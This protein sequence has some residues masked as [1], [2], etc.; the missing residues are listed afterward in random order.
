M[1]ITEKQRRALIRYTHEQDELW[2]LYREWARKDPEGMYVVCGAMRDKAEELD[3]KGMEGIAFNA[4]VCFLT[5]ILMEIHMP[6]KL[7][8]E[9]S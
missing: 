5:M 3:N 4:A 1:N 2:Q 9:D 7:D 8:T 6:G